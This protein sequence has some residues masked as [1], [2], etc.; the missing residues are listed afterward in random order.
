MSDFLKRVRRRLASNRPASFTI[1]YTSL[2]LLMAI[3]YVA[4]FSQA[5]NGPH[6]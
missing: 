4:L 2:A 1:E 3:A 6:N 5:A